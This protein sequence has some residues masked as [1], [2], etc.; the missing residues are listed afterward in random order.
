MR[1]TIIVTLAITLFFTLVH[2]MNI[3]YAILTDKEVGNIFVSNI[4]ANQGTGDIVF[5]PNNDTWY[6]GQHVNVTFKNEQPQETVSIF[7]FNQ[8]KLLAGGPITHRSFDFVVPPEAVSPPNGTSLLL[9]VRRENFYLQAVD[10]VTL[11]VLP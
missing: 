2:A 3:P 7:F 8:T 5:P 4:D 10:Y 1:L 9:A 11:H 6:V